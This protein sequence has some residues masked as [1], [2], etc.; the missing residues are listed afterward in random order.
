MV[1]EIFDMNYESLL[2]IFTAQIAGSIAAHSR[3]INAMDCN[4]DGLIATVSDDCY[5][6]V[7]K[8]SDDVEN[9][10][11]IFLHQRLFLHMIFRLH[12]NVI[13]ELKTVN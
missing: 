4:D 6:R 12:I 11:V 8:L 5:I 3:C 1:S 2:E 13:I 9:L 7:W 10:Q